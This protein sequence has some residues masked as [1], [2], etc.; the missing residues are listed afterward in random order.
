MNNKEEKLKKLLF[1]IIDK[2]SKDADVYHH[3]ENFW[4]IHTEDRKWIVEFT[5]ERTLWF[6]YDFF[7]S[8]FK[9][10]SLDVQDNKNYVTDWF[11][12]RFLNKPKV[13]DTWENSADIWHQVENT[14]QNGVMVTTPSPSV[15]GFLVEDTI[16]NGVKHTN[17][18]QNTQVCSVEDTIQNGVKHTVSVREKS[19]PLVEDT[20]Q[21]GV[22]STRT[23]P[24]P[25]LKKVE[26]IIQNGVRR[27]TPVKS[28]DIYGV[29]NDV[30]NV[31]RNTRDYPNVIKMMI[32]DTVENGV[33][34]TEIGWAQYNGVENAIENGVKCTQHME[35]RNQ[36]NVENVIEYGVKATFVQFWVDEK[37]VGDAIINGIKYPIKN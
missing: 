32:D 8:A 4:L 22:K 1:D 23:K 12:S 20:I 13:E 9:F 6:N 37:R 28:I 18:S 16:Q 33:R 35:N 14:I 15:S 5:K 25:L 21:N 31:R 24:N 11:K 19:K 27:T 7:R 3:R 2:L 10:V 29:E 30:Q 34:H 17:G 26:D 36:E